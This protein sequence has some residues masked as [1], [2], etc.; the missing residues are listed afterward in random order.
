MSKYSQLEAVIDEQLKP[1]FLRI[2][3][4]SHQHGGNRVESHFKVTIVAGVFEGLSLLKRHQSVYKV[5]Q[6]IMNQGIHALGLH[7][8]TED[9][10]LKRGGTIPDSPRCRGGSL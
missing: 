9:E 5:V 7:C 10:W 1:L 6:P 3:D 4:E 2:E 8:Y